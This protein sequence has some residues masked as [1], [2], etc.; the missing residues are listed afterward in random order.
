VPDN[1]PNQGDAGQHLGKAA[2]QVPIRSA[3]IRRSASTTMRGWR[4]F[5]DT[6]GFE[7]ESTPRRIHQI[8][9]LSICHAA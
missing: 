4:A 1:V 6:F 2:D 3:P 9:A 7:Y 5:L 8:A